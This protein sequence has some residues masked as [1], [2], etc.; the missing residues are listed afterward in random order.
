MQVRWLSR[1][2]GGLAFLSVCALCFWC[3]GCGGSRSDNTPPVVLTVTVNES[4]VVIPVGGTIYV[5]VTIVAP[6]ETVTFA[7]GGL[8]AG[9]SASYKESES[10]P[11]GQL[12][13]I[14]GGSAPVGSYK[15]TI[16]VGTSGQTAS[17][18][19]PLNVVAK[20]D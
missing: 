20:G 3:A 9:V 16:T 19:F 14:A 6:T 2:L 11:S 5:P 12:T 7:I 4:P 15:C 13:L 1:A 18:V 10:N 8:P 17:T